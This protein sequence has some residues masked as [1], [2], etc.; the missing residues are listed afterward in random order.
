MKK[1]HCTP[2]PL[3]TNVKAASSG[4]EYYAAL[5]VVSCQPSLPN[6]KSLGSAHEPA[7]SDNTLPYQDR[8]LSVSCLKPA[9]LLGTGTH[10]TRKL[11]KQSLCAYSCKTCF[12]LTVTTP[13][14][15]GL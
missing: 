5:H 11:A 15:H 6:Q 14:V 13:G 8:L 12:C 1:K 4:E 3:L 10:L 9:L 2:F 7:P